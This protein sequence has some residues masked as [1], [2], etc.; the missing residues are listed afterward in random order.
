MEGNRVWAQ[1]EGSAGSHDGTYTLS[2]QECEE[3]KEEHHERAMTLRK[4]AFTIVNP[5]E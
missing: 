3:N 5:E 2:A 1:Q 4:T